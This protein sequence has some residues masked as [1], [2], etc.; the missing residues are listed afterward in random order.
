M[1]GLFGYMN[2]LLLLIE[3]SLNIERQDFISKLREN[4]RLKLATNELFDIYDYSSKSNNYLLELGLAY[5]IHAL[6]CSL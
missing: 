6:L 2:E 4:S 5:N 1:T 3:S